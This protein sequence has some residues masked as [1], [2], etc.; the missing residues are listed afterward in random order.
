MRS[1]TIRMVCSRVLCL[2]RCKGERAIVGP[3]VSLRLAALS[4]PARLIGDV[5]PLRWAKGSKEAT[6]TPKGKRPSRR[7]T[8]KAG[9]TRFDC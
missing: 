1:V 3:N 2:R 6:A 7:G 4:R 9:Q 8:T 5:D